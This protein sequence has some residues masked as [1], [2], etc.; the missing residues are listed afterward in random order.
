[1][2]CKTIYKCDRCDHEQEVLDSSYETHGRKEGRQFWTIRLSYKGGIH[3]NASGYHSK[4]LTA[5][6]CR[7]CMAEMGML[8][9]NDEKEKVPQPDP[10]PTLEDFL[11]EIVREEIEYNQEG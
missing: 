9:V 11:R 1:M 5:H 7:T 3:S 4:D 10:A 6:W 8:E 2:S